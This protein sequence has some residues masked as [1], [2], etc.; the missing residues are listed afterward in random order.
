M[1]GHYLTIALRNFRR[2]KIH[3][4]IGVVGLAIGLVCFVGA[5]VVSDYVHGFEKGFPNSD[6][7]YTISQQTIIPGFGFRRTGL[8][9][10]A[11][12]VAK[13]LRSDFPDIKAAYTV[14]AQ[15]FGIRTS[16]DA[17][18]FRQIEFAEPDFLDIF[19][20]PFVI[21]IAGNPLARPHSAVIRQAVAEQ[22]FGD[23]NPLGQTILIN[24]KIDVTVTG[25]IGEL[26]SPTHLV[27]SYTGKPFDLIVNADVFDEMSAFGGGNTDAAKTAAQ[28]ETW[29]SIYCFTYVLLP[30]DG[31]LTFDRLNAQLA[32]FGDRHMPPAQGRAQFAAHPVSE[33]MVS[34]LDSFVLQ[35]AVGLSAT[36]ILLFL[37][38]LVLATACLNYANLAIA[39][40]AGRAKEV[41]MRK[42]LGAGRGQVLAQYMI[43]ALLLVGVALGLALIIVQLGVSALANVSSLDI[44]LPWSEGPAFWLFLVGVVVGVGVIAGGYPALVLARIRPIQALRAGN[45]RGGPRRLRM[46]LV[47][48]QFTAASFLLIAVMVIV[49]HNIALRKTGLGTGTAQHVVI[50]NNVLSAEIDPDTLRT[51]L[52]RD[53]RIEDV[54]FSQFTP[55]S[56]SIN[57]AV[58]GKTP[59]PAAAKQNNQRYNV[60]YDYFS[61]VGMTV[62]AG[63]N[64]S[65][66]R[67]DDI[68]AG[69]TPG[70]THKGPA[71]VVMDR[72]T[73][74]KMGWSDPRQAIGKTLYEFMPA[75]FGSD[76]RRIVETEVI[77][78]VEYQP[79]K[80]VSM[81][82]STNLYYLDPSR[83]GFPIIRISGKD[84]PGALAQIDKVWNDLAPN[85]P[86]KRKFMDEEFDQAYVTFEAIGAVLSLLASFAFVVAM[87]G[88]FGMAAMVA[89]RRRHEIGI[90]KT[91]GASTAQVLKMLIWD[92][93]KPVMIANLIAWP[94]AFVVM[95]GY[96]SLF[97]VR[98]P[99]TPVPFLLSL[100]ISVLI[101]WIAVG[102]HALLAARANPAAVLR[103]E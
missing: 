44:P 96:L 32:T 49:A 90:R 82:L 19:Q 66:D 88:L 81:G 21:K 91:M 24:N 12:P 80:L 34:L 25:V 26:P 84:I 20:L 76:E 8:P 16:T 79:L 54:G 13:Y 103:Y 11:K 58:T 64:F 75:G 60:S 18:S 85:L 17:K 31:S 89:R 2:H 99:L 97:T 36:V 93:S 33:L 78:V 67:S 1:I 71:H 100:A 3:T 53:P 73:A 28:A 4:A 45:V 68:W 69:F 47:G 83:A 40:A 101:A 86:L 38:G 70:E 92:F 30:A 62:L 50:E 56:F 98:I 87:L 39:Q 51:A 61:T 14:F 57:L 52:L 7:I 10:T 23:K 5:Y 9:I 43:E 77:G 74:E 15:E 41:G 94:F 95:L 65:R 46:L 63:R 72:Y 42:V 22:L 55:W 6:R 35:G 27:Q 29:N 37:G 102:A 59:D 48:V